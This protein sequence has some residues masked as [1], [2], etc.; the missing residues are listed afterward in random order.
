MLCCFLSLLIVVVSVMFA[1]HRRHRKASLKV[2]TSPQVV[3]D[4]Q[5][6]NRKGSGGGFYSYFATARRIWGRSNREIDTL[7]PTTY[8][9]TSSKNQKREITAIPPTAK[10][11]NSFLMGGHYYPGKDKKRRYMRKKTLWYR[12]FC[13]ST[14][15][16][17]STFFVMIYFVTW[18]GIVP[19]GNSVW[20]FALT[21]SSSEDS[22]SA[23][24]FKANWLQYDSTLNVPALR[25]EK[26]DRLQIDS[27]RKR[28]KY[29]DSNRKKLRNRLLEDIVP[30][31]F[32]RNKLQTNEPPLPPNKVDSS[33]DQDGNKKSSP[34]PHNY[35]RASEKAR[36]TTRGIETETNTTQTRVQKQPSQPI[37][38]AKSNTTTTR[39]T[40]PSLLLEKTGATLPF[41][42]INTM[43]AFAAKYSS[44]S[45]SDNT[46]LSTSLI[47]QT[48]TNRLWILKETCTRW[49]DPIIAVVF[50][51]HS[52]SRTGLEDN[53]VYQ[54][55]ANGCPHVSIIHYMATEEESVTTNYPVN[56]LRNVGLDAVTTSHIL[57]MDVDFVPS[58]NLHETVRSALSRQAVA[59]AA[60]GNDKGSNGINRQ[61]ALIV[62]AFERKPLEPCDTESDCATYLKSNS[63]F[64]PKTFSDLQHCLLLKDCTIFQIDV[65]WEG[66]YSTH[67]ERWIQQQWYSDDANTTLRTVP[68]FHSA[69]YEPYVVLQWC[70]H[71]SS[72]NQKPVAPYYDERFHG[73]G[74]NKIELISHLRKAGYQFSILPEGFIVHNPH[75]ESQVKRAWND[76][77]GS[78]LH[79]S[80][81]SLYNDFLHELDSKY[82]EIHNNTV[83]LCT[84]H[85]EE[86]QT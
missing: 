29:G 80:M 78:D 74:K 22:S 56:R 43:D 52:S 3:P 64:I 5:I 4:S 79:S 55:L 75:P 82:K 51:P 31:W 23:R 26:L 15:R 85:T 40:A 36:T 39:K 6:G 2:E 10:T 71:N 28:L 12:V 77:Q 57:V 54:D 58:S 38:A 41:R 25:I 69:R 61:Q 60:V 9:S 19:L 72:S 48:S 49:M 76:K 35:E 27:E 81:D 44:C 46:R 20:H 13:S 65:N 59:T 7:L 17:F 50:L 16:R 68:C 18:H 45:A 11:C 73:Y 83:K 62:P 8:S 37:D 14:W 42:T 1:P 63:S 70:N 21:I 30:A 86:S 24:S 84:K 32:G 47:I 33:S 34:T 67:S 66:H 53:D